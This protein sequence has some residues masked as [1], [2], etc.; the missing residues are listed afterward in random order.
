MTSKEFQ[1]QTKFKFDKKPL[2][3]GAQKKFI[4]F[5]INDLNNLSE[6]E[7]E[8]AMKSFN[9]ISGFICSNRNLAGKKTDNEYLVINT[10]EPYVNEIVITLKKN[11]HWN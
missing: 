4:V 1:N 7:R 10:D 3:C 5:N 8:F 11:G 9:T 2:R 6:Q